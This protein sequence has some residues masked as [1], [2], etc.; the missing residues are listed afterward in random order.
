MVAQSWV[1][2]QSWDSLTRKLVGVWSSSNFLYYNLSNWSF[3][4]QIKYSVLW[5]H[6][7]KENSPGTAKI[8][9]P[10]CPIRI[11]HQTTWRTPNSVFLVWETVPMSSSMKQQRSLMTASPNWEQRRCLILE[12]E[13]IRSYSNL[14]LGFTPSN[15][16]G[17]FIAFLLFS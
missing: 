2:P 3:L 1:F 17:D 14:H 15:W 12:W 16:E 6:V 8:F 4:F 11:Y 7:V 9:G 5:P 10:S 13:M